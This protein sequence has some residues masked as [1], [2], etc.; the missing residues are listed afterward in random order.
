MAEPVKLTTEEYAA[1]LPEVP[2]RPYQGRLQRIVN[3]TALQSKTPPDFFF[4]SGRPN[5]Y[6]P[7]GVHCLYFSEDA[8]TAE[9]ERARYWEG[10][11]GEH[12]PRVTYF[13]EVTLGSVL[14][15]ENEAVLTALH[16]QPSDLHLPW[17]FAS[18]LTATQRLGAAVAQT[19]RF[20]AIRYPSDAARERHR[21][22][23]NL[24]IFLDHVSAPDRLA[25][26]GPE[27][28]PLQVWPTPIP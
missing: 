27:D 16:L 21:A 5:R 6:N 11:P 17:R 13:A 24:G 8:E 28:E 4:A 22:G 26:L 7:R 20:S 14:D 12:Q 2:V 25:I 9:A 10:Q 1:L 23:W 19:G 15:L 3:L 18:E